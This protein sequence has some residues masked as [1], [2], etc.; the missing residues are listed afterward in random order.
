M[1]AELTSAEVEEQSTENPAE[2]E[3]IEAFPAD[4]DDEAVIDDQ[5]GVS[6]SPAPQSGP[7]VERIRAAMQSG[8]S[9]QGK[10]IGWNDGG[11]H[12]VVHDVAAFCPHSEMEIG[13]PLDPKGYVDKAYDFFVLRIE[14]E[15]KRIVL[16][17]VS[18]LRQEEKAQQPANRGQIKTGAVLTGKVVTVKDFGAFVELGGVQGLV[19]ISELARRRVERTEDVVQVG[20]D[21]EVKVLKVDKGGRRISL[22]MKALEP[23]PWRDAP[24]KYPVGSTAQGRVE[25]VER[26]GAF[27]QLEPGLS[28]LLPASKMSI[29]AGTTAARVFRPGRELTVQVL[30]IDSRRQRISLGLEGDSSEG[31]RSDF[32]SYLHG[33]RDEKG[34]F[35]ALAAALEKL[36]E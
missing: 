6:E 32:E 23:D 1:C 2:A 29:P 35:N 3:G 31:S 18:H 28:G 4:S 25:K 24:K 36:Q 19:H 11:M 16:S 27:V 20:D 26:F 15:G 5:A 12:V 33:Q 30:S 34:G 22:S 10:V 21:V 9:V 17:R 8:S 7:E 14:N 13:E